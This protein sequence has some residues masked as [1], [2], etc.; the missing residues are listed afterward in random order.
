MVPRGPTTQE[1]GAELERKGVL[2]RAKSY[3]RTPS[4]TAPRGRVVVH[5]DDNLSAFQRA[6]RRNRVAGSHR[7]SGETPTTPA[8]GGIPHRGAA[9]QF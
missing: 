8:L 9:A 3:W 5:E 6:V 7:T 2:N 1:E 4:V